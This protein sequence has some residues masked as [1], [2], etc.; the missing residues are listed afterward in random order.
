VTR[1]LA[2]AGL[3]VLLVVAA[4]V[5][6]TRLSYVPPYLMQ[7]EVNFSLQAHAIATTGHDTN[8]RFMPLYF[9][10]TGFEA[11]RD[12]VMI[13]WTAL[14]LTIAPLSESSVRFPT[15]L[16]AVLTI[17][18]MFFL[19]RRVFASEGMGLLAAALLAATPG[20]FTNA[21]LALSI[22]YAT[23][24]IVAWLYCTHR[25]VE[26]HRRAWVVASG[27]CLGIG[28]YTYLASLIVMPVLLLAAVAVFVAMGR[29][30][31]ARWMVAGFAVML[32]PLALWLIFHP[33]RFTNLL[34]AYRPSDAA[35]AAGMREQ[36]TAFWMFFSPDYLFLTGD[37]RLTNSTR[38]AGL[39]PLAS[40]VL[41]PIGLYRLIQKDAGAVGFLVVAGFMLSPL[42]TA[43]SGRLEINRVLHVLPFGVLAAVAGLRYMW[44]SG[45]SARIAGAVLTLSVALQFASFYN[46]YTGPYRTQAAAWFGGNSRTA[47]N[48]VLDQLGGES[49]PVYLN[50]RTP[51]ERYW[52]FFA[53]ARRRDD[54]TDHPTYFEPSALE[55]DT[56]PPGSFIV[57]ESDIGIGKQ[58]AGDPRWRHVVAATLPDGMVSHDVFERL[59]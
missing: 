18:G 8:R 30:R 57:C 28:L 13:Y 47:I 31:D 3:V 39:F 19:G 11:G 6:L 36:V 15:A 16:L 52:K 55:P 27:V 43:A 58:L 44:M 29:S 24:I 56:L 9:A 26:G 25:A 14:F 7:D 41:I 46:N 48:A 10:E 23:P 49:R 40:A 22:V 51:I 37:G 5:Y 33:D 38:F 12:P 4:A 21:R 17:G 2:A 50:R 35:T 20:Y 42:A 59:R 32:A 45:G 34:A 53:A 1:P 54:L